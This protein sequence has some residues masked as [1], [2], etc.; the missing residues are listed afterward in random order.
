VAT[1]I[2]TAAS[3]PA[4]SPSGRLSFHGDGTTLF[5]LYI[6]TLFLT[7]ITLGVYY[8]WAR[9]RIRSYILS[10]IEFEADRFAWHGTGKELFLGFLKIAVFFL[11]LYAV[12]A[13]IRFG[14]HHPA[15]EPVLRLGGTII[16]LFLVP[17][18]MVGARRYRLSRASWRGIRFSFRGRAR[19]FVRVFI[20]G[21]LLSALTLGLYYPV[22]LN[23]MRRY[24]VNQSYFGTSP[25]LY[26]GRGKDLFWRFLL[27]LVI[28]IAGIGS[29]AGLLI[30]TIR[31]ISGVA[32]APMGFAG[33]PHVPRP[34][35]ARAFG[36]IVGIPILFVILLSFIWFW[37]AAYRNRYYWG[38]TSFAGVHFRST[39]SVLGLMKL[40]AINLLLIVVTLGLALPW[41]LVRKLRFVFAN[42]SL[43]GP[44]DLSAIQQDTQDA[45]PVG[46]ALGD[47][48]DIGFFNVDLGI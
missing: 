1:R 7:L 48:L 32:V 6:I 21:T 45:S 25:F 28:A 20:A 39:V 22:F 12:A 29:L 31:N 18:A 10:Q 44:V 3:G 14:W 16:G 11:V 4:P 30:F 19:E 41:V 15:A 33:A 27:V 17:I 46:G 24:L 36:I 8:F 2:G 23:N 13:A 26:D 37:Y 38:H 35:T 40:T 5:G 47:I 34:E 9:T 43:E 42:V